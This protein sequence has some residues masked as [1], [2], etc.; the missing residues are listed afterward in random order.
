MKLKFKYYF[1][2]NNRSCLLM[3]TYLFKKI[4]FKADV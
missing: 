4:I 3:P 1:I 2:Q